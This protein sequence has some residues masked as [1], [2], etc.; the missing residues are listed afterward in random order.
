MAGTKGASS[1][2]EIELQLESRGGAW[3]RVMGG[4]PDDRKIRLEFHGRRELQ[5]IGKF[6]PVFIFVL[7]GLLCRV[8]V[9]PDEPDTRGVVPAGRK[10]P[11][12]F[13][14]APHHETGADLSTSIGL[15]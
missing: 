5:N 11:D 13:Q 1:P 3:L 15:R 12:I 2:G 9:T 4:I 6:K 10:Q 8:R 7:Y 14:R